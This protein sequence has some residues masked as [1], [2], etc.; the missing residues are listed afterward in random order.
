MKFDF[1]EM[2]KQIIPYIVCIVGASI[3]IGLVFSEIIV[4]YTLFE[5]A[6]WNP[7]SNIDFWMGIIASLLG[8]SFGTA[9]IV[10]ALVSWVLDH[11]FR[12]NFK[13][14][15]LI[16][17]III[18]ILA[19]VGIIIG[20]FSGI[21]VLGNI[22]TYPQYVMFYLVETALIIT[23]G[24]VLGISTLGGILVLLRYFKQD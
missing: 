13:Y 8:M 2:M 12:E 1:K 21:M 24:G 20:I 3:S 6:N 11:I 18:L 10:I 15:T 5:I 4:H 23:A 14:I 22:A 16:A 17:S 19:A 9:I 7:L